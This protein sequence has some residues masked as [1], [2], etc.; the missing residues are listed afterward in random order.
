MEYGVSPSFR[1][2][3]AA[4]ATLQD[5]DYQHYFSVSYEDWKGVIEAM[6]AELADASLGQRLVNH[7]K[8]GENVYASTFADGS[9][10]YVNYGGE[11]VRINGIQI[12]AMD[13][14]REEAQQ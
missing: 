9:V 7:E 1:L 6:A 5:T 14:V 10:V 3:A 2:M 8:L 11:A 12:P 4:P 13:F